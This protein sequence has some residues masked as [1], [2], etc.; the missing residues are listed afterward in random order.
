MMAWL[1]KQPPGRLHD[2]ILILVAESRAKEDP[3]AFAREIGPLLADNPGLTEM[4]GQAWLEW[5]KSGDHPD[6]AMAW[7]QVHGESIESDAWHWG[8]WTEESAGRVLDHLAELPNETQKGKFMLRVVRGL[9]SAN[10]QEALEKGRDLLPPGRETDRFFADALSSLAWRDPAGSLEW[11][12]ENLNDGPRRAGAIRSVM[13]SWTHVNPLAAMERARTIPETLKPEVYRTIARVW[14]NATPD[15]ALQHLKSSPDPE[16][17]NYLAQATF[18]NLGANRGGEAYLP[19]ALDLPTDEL[20]AEAVKGLFQGWSGS[21]AET[22]AAA[23]QTF[24]PGPLRDIAIGEFVRKVEKVDAEAAFAWTLEI[25]EADA[26]QGAV[27]GQGKRWLNADRVVATRWI[28]ANES[29][30]IEWKTE[31]L[32]TGD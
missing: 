26:R 17:Q 24:E 14:T 16:I 7:F 22:A 30:P 10:P 27:L 6:A 28:E 12:L 18:S 25:G 29:I 13:D 15:Q 1:T 3:A 31:L 8:E 23:L 32:A 21:N 4:A 11:A 5:L 19:E 2:H 20:K 9:A